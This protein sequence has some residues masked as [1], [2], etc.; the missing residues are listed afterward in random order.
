MYLN[1]LEEEKVIDR[2]ADSPLPRLQAAQHSDYDISGSEFEN[3]FHEPENGVPDI[4]E[5]EKM[6]GG[7]QQQGLKIA[8]DLIKELNT[9]TRNQEEDC[10]SEHS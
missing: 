6:V 4:Q 2:S 10:E 1:D 3:S 5:K 8:I 9:D 7:T